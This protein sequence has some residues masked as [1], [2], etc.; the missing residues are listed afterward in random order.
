M[1]T[2][3]VCIT[4]WAAARSVAELGAGFHTSSIGNRREAKRQMGVISNQKVQYGG[5]YYIKT[6]KVGMLF[7][8]FRGYT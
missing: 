2:I 8:K 7:V 5:F 4:W 3:H 6:R 1:L